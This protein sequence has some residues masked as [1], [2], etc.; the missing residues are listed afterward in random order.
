MGEQ[1]GSVFI[2][3]HEFDGVYFFNEITLCN[4]GIQ[5]YL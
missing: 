3:L 2:A 4:F 5:L 1:V